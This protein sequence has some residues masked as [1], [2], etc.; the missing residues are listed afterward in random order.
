MARE[1]DRL[2]TGRARRAARATGAL[3]PGTVRLLGSLAAS[4]GRSP[5][6]SGEVLTRRHD[7]LAEH[8]VQVLAGMKG[9]AMKIGQLASFV[10][11][12]LLPP[13]YRE[14][15]QERLADLRDSAPP[16]PWEKVRRVVETEWGQPVGELF[17]ELEP[18][19]AAAASI[20]QVHRGKLRDGRPVAV[21]VQYP[22]VADAL[23]AD[24][25]TATILIRLAKAIAPGLDPAEVAGELRERVLEEVD[26]ELE[27]ANQRDFARAYRDHPFIHVPGVVSEL[28]T[29]RVLVSE[30]AD[31][32]RFAEV[33]KLPQ[34][35]RDRFGEIVFRFGF[36]S[37]S[38]LAMYNSD[39]HP[40]NYL[41]RD[42]GRVSFLDFGSVKRADHERSRRG[43]RTLMA[44]AD[45]DAEGLRE[46]LAALGYLRKPDRASA[47]RWLAQTRAVT[48]W[49][50]EDREVTVDRAL[51]ARLIGA[52]AAPEWAITLARETRVPPDEVMFRR[53]QVGVLAVLGQLGATRNWPAIVREWWFGDEART[54]EGRADQEFWRA[55]GRDEPLLSPRS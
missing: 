28:S 3:A 50:L 22:E 42:D 16:M 39:V 12:D 44:A 6:R 37:L 51:V 15:W 27:A 36:G 10:D 35:E 53:L 34:P 7:E 5:E 46:Q 4:I 19:A 40:G 41:L 29:R 30:W 17:A 25:G 45:G 55:R 23:E 33:L 18:E 52:L 49:L 47:D 9:G 38:R 48:G 8:A 13:E 1:P 31:G 43:A 2:P 54:E 14:I 26:Y 21:K 24:V 32:M 20:G 11:V